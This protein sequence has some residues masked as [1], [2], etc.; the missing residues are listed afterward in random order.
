MKVEVEK[1]KMKK[2][3]KQHLL[4]LFSKT[5]NSKFN[6]NKKIWLLKFL[7]RL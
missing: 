7:Q 4:N 5:S 2:R 3:K 1:Y 6:T